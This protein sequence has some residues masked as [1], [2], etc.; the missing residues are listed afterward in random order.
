MLLISVSEMTKLRDVEQK[1]Q[2]LAR[3]LEEVAS[4]LDRLKSACETAE[5]VKMAEKV[6]E[7][8]SSLEDSMLHDFCLMIY[9]I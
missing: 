8:K 5:K 3:K 9:S 4:E 1:S 6:E 7:S 2:D